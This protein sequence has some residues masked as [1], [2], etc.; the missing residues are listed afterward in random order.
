MP[1]AVFRRHQRKLLAIFAILAMFGFVLADSLP[2]LLSPGYGGARQDPVVVE[3]YGKTLHRSDLE[4]MTVQRANA[5]RFMAALTGRPVFGTHNT[6][7]IVDALILQHEADKLKMPKGPDAGREWLKEATDGRMNRTLFEATLSSFGNQVSGEQILSDIASQVRIL[8]VRRLLGSPVVTPLDVY[9]AYRDQNERVAARAV[10]LPVEGFLAKVPEPT[11]SQVKAFYDKYKDVLPDPNRDTPGFK[12]P[13]QVQVEFLTIDGSALALKLK[14]TL[15]EPELHSYYESRKSEFKKTSAFPD[16]I[17]AG[18]PELTP[19]Q[20]QSFEE[21]RPYLATSLADEKA[22]AEIVAKFGKITDDVIIPFT[23]SY[24]EAS[25]AIADAK[26]REEKTTVQLPKPTSLK[27][28]ASKEGMEHEISPLLS[29]EQA[30]H[31][32]EISGAEVGLTKL[33]GGRKFAGELF[34]SKTNLFEPIELT[35]LLGHRYLARKLDDREPRVPSLDEVRSQVVLAWKT[36]QA[37]PLAEKAAQDLASEI[38]KAGGKIEGE[39]IQGHPVIT[40]LPLTRLQPGFPLPGQFF[41]SGPPTETEIPN[42]PN[43]G[44]AFRNAYFQLEPGTVTVVPNQPK[45]SYYVLT[46][47]RRIPATFASLYAPSGEYLRYKNEAQTDAFRRLEDDWMNRL[48]ADAGLKADWVPLDE[49]N[50][51]SAPASTQG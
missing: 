2:R 14:D 6:R 9:K 18:H 51:D 41:Q 31:Y 27:D 8:K 35:D 15:A 50:R 11:E 28:V 26:K 43:P 10:A 49:V 25:D 44:E 47:D 23:N 37:R 34:D 4:E 46:L 39:T 7:A 48:R 45:T 17:F 33:S 38:R 36:E 20:V 16:E 13:R 19:P 3:L 5:N 42:I 21:V 30:E 40:T 29:R 12:I 24:L 1:F 32:G 22:Q